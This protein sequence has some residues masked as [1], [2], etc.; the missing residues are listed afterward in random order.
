MNSKTIS[1]IL[2]FCFPA[3]LLSCLDK[4][5]YPDIPAIEYKSFRM[6][7]DTGGIDQMGVLTVFFTDGDGDVGLAEGDTFPPYNKEGDDYYNCY[8][9]YYEKQNGVVKRIELPFENN[10]R[11]PVLS[12]LG[13]NKTLKGDIDITLFVNNPMS[14]YDTI[15][16]DV[17][18]VDRSLNQSNTVMTQEL[19]VKKR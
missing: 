10:Y 13:H 6:I 7:A 17:M 1:K 5:E 16:F 14:I 3:I 8:I 15:L 18:I 9:G 2:L 12:P 11:I 19:V 4:E